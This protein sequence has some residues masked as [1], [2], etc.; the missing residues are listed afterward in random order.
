[1]VILI[2]VH[3]LCVCENNTVQFLQVNPTSLFLFFGEISAYIFY[4]ITATQV[5]KSAPS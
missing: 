1:M 2:N 5:N 4:E 3:Y